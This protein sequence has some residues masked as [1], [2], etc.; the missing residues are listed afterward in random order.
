MAR[1][2]ACPPWEEPFSEEL[3]M[4]LLIVILVVDVGFGVW[5]SVLSVVLLE[6]L[7]ESSLDAE[8]LETTE[9]MVLRSILSTS[10]YNVGS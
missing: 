8:T 2:A 1:S 6:M 3:P 5:E 10:W 4:K 9:L 7:E